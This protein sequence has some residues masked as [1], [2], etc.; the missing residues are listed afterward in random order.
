MRRTKHSRWSGLLAA[1]AALTV[2]AATAAGPAAAGTSRTEAKEGISLLFVLDAGSGTLKKVAGDRYTLTLRTTRPRAVAFSDAPTR[3]ATTMK[4]R[5]IVERWSSYFPK[6]KQPNAA[7]NL[8]TRDGERN[9]TVILELDAPAMKGTTVTFPVRLLKTGTGRIA[10][11][12]AR[13]RS[14]V[15][16]AFRDASLFIDDLT[17][18][19]LWRFGEVRAVG[20]KTTCALAMDIA[21]AAQALIETYCGQ[22]WD[23]CQL[24]GFSVDG[25]AL[26]RP[27]FLPGWGAEYWTVTSADSTIQVMLYY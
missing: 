2:L 24:P 25:V 16:S 8:S 27:S 22:D 18:C 26:L 5:K 3:Y 6:G 15:P 17:V 1:A 20:A 14:T 10:S 12:N 4:T 9:D 11:F 13:A 23:D 19:G 7:L 21:N